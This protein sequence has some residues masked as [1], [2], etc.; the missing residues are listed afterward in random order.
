MVVVI[1]HHEAEVDSCHMG[2][3]GMYREDV[4]DTEI[5]EVPIPI[6]SYRQT[7]FYTYSSYA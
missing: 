3:V 4:E 5:E 2:V 7:L 1:L 6:D